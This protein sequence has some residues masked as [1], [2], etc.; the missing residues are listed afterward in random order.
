MD[1]SD[2]K[3]KDASPI[4]LDA[5]SVVNSIDNIVNITPI[6][7]ISS[8]KL[9]DTI[10]LENLDK[11][12]ELEVIKENTNIASILIGEEF[13]VTKIT[14][15][16]VNEEPITD[17]LEGEYGLILAEISNLSESNASKVERDVSDS[18]TP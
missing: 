6:T 12:K 2:G 3:E 17:S 5:I 9:K 13:D 16:I 15:Q 11:E 7:T 4:S 10:G 14:P 1:E 8:Q 18:C